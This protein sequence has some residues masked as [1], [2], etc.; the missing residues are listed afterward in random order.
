VIIKDKM[1]GRRVE[2]F[3]PFDHNGQRIEAVSIGPFLLDHTLRWDAGKFKSAIHLL[4]TLC[5]CEES[6]LGQLRYPDVDRV[7]QT[8]YEMVPATVRSHMERGEVPLPPVGSAFEEADE[9]DED[10]PEL[11]PTTGPVTRAEG[12]FNP[13][14]PWGNI[15]ERGPSPG[16]IPNDGRDDVSGESDPERRPDYGGMDLDP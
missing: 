6:L 16:F 2:L 11:T 3:I 15:T 14:D 9:T 7:F 10:A 12:A 5:E 1:G 13:A 4:A 8:F